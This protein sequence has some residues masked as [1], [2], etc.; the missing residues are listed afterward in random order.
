MCQELINDILWDIL[1]KYVI[2]YFNNM[3]IYLN[4]IFKNYII[5]MKK[6]LKWFNN[7]KL[8]F[9]P[10]KC[11]FYQEKVKFLGYIIGKNGICINPIKIKTILKWPILINIKEI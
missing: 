5:K 6:V 11:K 2:V 4:R 3:L 10:E 7:R 8:L 9:K 1:D